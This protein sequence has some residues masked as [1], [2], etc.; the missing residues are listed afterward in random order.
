MSD[1]AALAAKER[2]NF[3]PDQTLMDPKVPRSGKVEVVM[4]DSRKRE[5]FTP[6]ACGTKRNPMSTADVS[7]K[8]RDLM[9]PVLG[10]RRTEG[11]IQRVNALQS[12]GKVCELLPL[13]AV[14]PHEMAKVTPPLIE[15]P[16]ASRSVASCSGAAPLRAASYDSAS[17]VE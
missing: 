1:P 17:Q 15:S 8:V 2:V 16:R 10:A 4:K 5:H 13:L 11:V 6:H 14:E 3:I 7:A 12:I 9:A